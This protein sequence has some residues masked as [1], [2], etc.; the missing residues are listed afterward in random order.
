MSR[1]NK[2]LE[3]VVLASLL[4]L[5]VMASAQSRYGVGPVTVDGT[6]AE[7]TKEGAVATL[8]KEGSVVS[9]GKMAG[10]DP[11]SFFLVG[12]Q[13]VDVLGKKVDSSAMMAALGS[14]LQAGNGNTDTVT[15]TGNPVASEPAWGQ[16]GIMAYGQGAKV[17]VQ[18]K[19]IAISTK[20]ENPYS[21]AVW[22]QNNTSDKVAPKDAASVSLN[23]DTISITAPNLGIVNYSNGQINI[24]GDLTLSA[25]TAISARGYSTTNINTDGKHSTVI[26][27]NIEFET[28]AT[29]SD[30][31]N[32]GNDID[33]NVN[34]NLN[35][36]ESVW[37][38]RAYEKYKDEGSE[39]ESE[40]LS[41][42]E[43]VGEDTHLN[44]TMNDGAT[45]NV[46]GDTIMGNLQAD[47]STIN[48]KPAMT[49]MNSN[50]MNLNRST[51]NFEGTNQ[52]INVESLSGND[53]TINTASLDNQLRVSKQ[54]DAKNL[55][56]HGTGAIADS[57]ARDNSNAQKLANVAVMA[58][59]DQ[60]V[61]S[62][63]TTDE[64]VLAGTYN[65]KVTDGKVDMPHSTYTPN[66]TNVGIASMATMNLMT[67]RQENNDMNKRLGEL[68]DSKGKEGVWARM[69]RGEAKYSPAGL[70][71][72]YNYY[73]VGYDI[74]AGKNWTVGAA[75][76]KTDGNT[77]FSRGKSDND[78]NGVALYGSYLSDD[79]SFVDLIGKYARL[80]T[81]YHVVG[82]VGDGDY[83]TNAYSFSAEY[84]KRFHGQQGFWVEPQ[85]EL[86][87]GRVQS[88]DYTTSNRVSVHQDSM[89]SFVGRLGFSLGKDI[90]AGNV[91]ARASYLYDFDGE[92]SVT[93]AKDGVSDAYKQDIGGGWWEVGV[94]T[95]LNLSK[96][97]HMYID[98]EKTYG[99]DVT[100]PWQWGLGMRYS[101]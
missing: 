72:Q 70:K 26:N 7:V 19:N 91:Y 58:D 9:I 8:G 69:V 78:H 59:T 3:A 53:A 86:T 77:T 67:W 37:N 55:T 93:M 5:P 34:L 57:I 32:S 56:I 6:A 18:A 83:D 14:N 50:T 82:G 35:G 15:I 29:K 97:T 17:T 90:K 13:K 44:L 80:D 23:G 101:F 99:G 92:T 65:L 36:T 43:Y 40:H 74:K 10:E 46:T 75:Y 2:A 24:N 30:P 1:K 73:Q 60:S 33:A 87:Y 51:L 62:Q 25:P 100:T 68:R 39:E 27:G 94:G 76:S 16:Y 54:S 61:A 22:A 79:G 41:G 89:D 20:S 64:G 66:V 63:I 4:A 11:Y 48:V 12:N 71:N 88:A 47:S 96:A 31:H 85:A 84:G 42:N 38:G 28:P 98:L 81:D 49:R 45:W 21:G 95:N 52:L